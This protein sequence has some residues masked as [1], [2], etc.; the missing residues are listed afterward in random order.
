TADEASSRIEETQFAQPGIFAVQVGLLA[1]WR[2]WGIEPAAI[3]G[4]SV[5]E[6]AAAYAAGALTFADATAGIFHRSRLQ[7][8]PTGRGRM[9]AAGLAASDA[10]ALLAGR[11]AEVSIAAI[12]GPASVTLSGDTTM[13]EV[14]RQELD[15]RGIFARFLQV[16]VP[17]HSAKMDPLADE[18]RASLR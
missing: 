2:S 15:Q 14:L 17:Y 16:D 1:L 7:H 3:I 18:L 11:D 9:L 8:R 4:H 6:I 10:R 13:L 5:G 12:N